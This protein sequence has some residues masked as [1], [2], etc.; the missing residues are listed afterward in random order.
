MPN[1]PKI[2]NGIVLRAGS[3]IVS[4]AEKVILFIDKPP[5]ITYF[6]QRRVI[7]VKQAH[8]LDSQTRGERKKA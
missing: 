4:S 8:M 3:V 7:A 1:K 2:M 5:K 6:N